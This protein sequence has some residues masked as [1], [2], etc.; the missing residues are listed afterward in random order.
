MTPDI[1]R[2]TRENPRAEE[3]NSGIDQYNLPLF[4]TLTTEKHSYFEYG[5][6]DMMR[7]RVGDEDGERWEEKFTA[8]LIGWGVYESLSDIDPVLLAFAAE[9]RDEKEAY[10]MFEKYE[11]SDADIHVLTYLNLDKAKAFITDGYES[12][13]DGGSNDQ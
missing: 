13:P 9:T 8:L 6:V 10:E 11:S 2:G 12:L 3:V 5:S 7:E 4:V 1:E